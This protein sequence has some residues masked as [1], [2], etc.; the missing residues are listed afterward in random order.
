MDKLPL[1]A[2]D[3]VKETENDPLL[4]RVKHCILSGWPKYVTDDMLKP[5]E[6]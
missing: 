6:T 4:S 5:F 1:T 2:T 3:I